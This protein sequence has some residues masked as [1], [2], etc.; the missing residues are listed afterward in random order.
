M[1]L[2]LVASQG[3]V[4]WKRA[5]E[6]PVSARLFQ[7]T[8]QKKRQLAIGS[9]QE[10][11]ILQGYGQ[12][13]TPIVPADDKPVSGLLLIEAMTYRQ[14]HHS[15]SDD[16]L[17][18]RSAEEVQSFADKSDPLA[19]LQKFLDRQKLMTGNDFKQVEDDEKMAVI[20]AM[21]NAERKPKPPLECLF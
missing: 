1:S 2:K 13:A 4:D 20:D 14:G 9:E 6:V 12:I 7:E 17:R 16:S 10:E 19:R 21:R 11:E 15:T 3:N 5:E 18:Y 8:I